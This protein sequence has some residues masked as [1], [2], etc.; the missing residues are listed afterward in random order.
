MRWDALFDDLDRQFQQLNDATEDAEQADQIRVEIGAVAMVER[1]AGARGG[2]VRLRLAG[3]RLVSGRL[4]RLGPDWLLLIE[5]VAT[6]LL[7]PFAALATVEGVTA[8]T[9]RA[10][11]TVD[12]RFDLRK[13]LRGVGRDRAPVGVLTTFGAEVTGT[14]DRVGADFLELATHAAWEVRRTD[15]V[16]SVLLVP[17]SAIVMV[18]AVPIG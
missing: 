6:D 1:L 4:D 14:I 7:I 10:L 11:G 16:R 8:S 15:A 17:L 13:A 3:G 12:S 2:Q 5:S 9:G 18:R